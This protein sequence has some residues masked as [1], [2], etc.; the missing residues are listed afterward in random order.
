MLR[1]FRLLFCLVVSL[2]RSH[3]NLLLENLALR[4]VVG[5]FENLHFPSVMVSKARATPQ[6]GSEGESN[7]A[8]N[9]S[10]AMPQQGVLPRH[11]LL[12]YSQ[13]SFLEENSLKLHSKGKNS[14]GC[15][16]LRLSRLRRDSRGAQHDK[17]EIFTSLEVKLTHYPPPTTLAFSF[18]AVYL[19]TLS[20]IICS[21]SALRTMRS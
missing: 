13:K 19:R 15:F 7:H 2:F 17:S 5:H 1:S 11:L 21:S 6:R 4:Q 10:L 8:D 20:G 9:L 12:R 16:G 14:R 3:R 18:S